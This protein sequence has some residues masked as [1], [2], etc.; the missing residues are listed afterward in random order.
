MGIGIF[1]C[2]GR[3]L[4]ALS[5][6]DRLRGARRPG[7]DPSTAL[8]L[9]ERTAREFRPFHANS[10][11]VAA[12][13]VTTPLAL[14]GAAGAL[15]AAA[16][17]GSALAWALCGA[18]ALSLL[19]C[20]PLWVWLV[21]TAVSA[22]TALAAGQLAA[23]GGAAYCLP[24]LVVGYA[25]QELAHLA[26]GEATY[27][28]SYQGKQGWLWTLAVH[29]WLLVPLLADAVWH[30]D[31]SILAWPVPFDHV[32][33]TK[34]TASQ[35]ASNREA[36]RN[37]VVAQAP[38]KEHT[39]H[40]W[41]ERLPEVAKRPFDALATCEALV[42]MFRTRFPAPMYTVE[43]VFGMNEIYVSSDKHNLN[44]DTVFYMLHT[45]GPWGVF[46]LCG[47][48]RCMMSCSE[49]T[50]VATRFPFCSKQY[51]L[52]D[53]DV[54]GFDFN[55]EIH[56]IKDNPGCVNENH[57]ITLKLHYVVYPTCLKPYGLLLKAVTQTYNT[58]ARL[59][60][61]NTITPRGPWRL[62]AWVVLAL[63]KL[64]FN[65]EMYA[66]LTN[67]SYVALCALVAWAVGDYQVLV[68]L[69]SF[70]HYFM[71]IGTYHAALLD[72]RVSFGQFKRDVVFFKGVA[73]AHLAWLYATNFDLAH[74]PFSLALVVCGY[75]LA[76]AAAAALGLDQTYFGAELGEVKPRFVTA[77]P[78]GKWGV[79]HPMIIGALVGLSGLACMP[80]LWNAMPWLVPTH[81]A[82]YLAHCLQEE[83]CDMYKGKAKKGM[84]GMW[85]GARRRLSEGYLP[86]LWVAAAV[87]AAA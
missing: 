47:L 36:V 19:P 8:P 77:F 44:S 83:V 21:S 55:R 9:F 4:A 60:F 76:G 1:D 30:T 5:V 82:F 13:L 87:E 18:Y 81:M 23:A 64:R 25:V 40:W 50:Q 27:Q 42:A 7:G 10:V 41:H 57:R 6:H 80:G 35:D 14:A 86:S 72:L 31:D 51:T 59:T 12:H 52:T 61:L 71:Y 3:A 43:P 22:L 15:D 56:D 58:L 78:Y 33:S 74:A 34:L 65:T 49:N 39:T 37:W 11:N 24:A 32:M 48:Y 20:V 69:T 75:G 67:V 29:T 28:G 73:Y 2:A 38:S 79:P 68:V 66:G 70:V 63:T 62:M 84:S 46:P 17:A 85:S 54:V 16:G 53:G 26:T 45:D